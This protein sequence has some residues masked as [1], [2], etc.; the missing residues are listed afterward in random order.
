MDPQRCTNQVHKYHV[1]WGSKNGGR[2]LQWSD[3]YLLSLQVQVS[4][5]DKRAQN[6]LK[7]QERAINSQPL[8]K[9]LARKTTKEQTY[10]TNVMWATRSQDTQTGSQ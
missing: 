6:K 5:T 3:I 7:H 1:T 2:V 10:I 9:K 8:K 4:F